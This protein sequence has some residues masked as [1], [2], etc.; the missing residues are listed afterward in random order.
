MLFIDKIT[1][2]NGSRTDSPLNSFS[3][4]LSHTTGQPGGG[5]IYNR[6]GYN[7]KTL[8]T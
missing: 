1:L 5:T 6:K 4:K 7:Q 2:D 3:G 8:T